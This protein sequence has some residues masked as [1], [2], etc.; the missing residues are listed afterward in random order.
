MHTYTRTHTQDRRKFG[1]LGWNIR[2][3]FTDGD[4]G[5]SL[6]Q[7]KVGSPCLVL[8][9]SGVS[10]SQVE[11]GSPCLWPAVTCGLACCQ[12]ASPWQLPFYVQLHPMI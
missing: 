2:Y 12:Q 10:L 8:A 5:V 4:L 7:M 6:A 9:G 3:D 1:P 11:V